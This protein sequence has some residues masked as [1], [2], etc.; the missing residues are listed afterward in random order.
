MVVE[1]TCGDNVLVDL[2]RMTVYNICVSNF[3]EGYLK[4][5]MR[6]TLNFNHLE[7]FFCLAKSLSF[8]K[9]A[10]QLGLAQPVV[11]R[12]IKALEDHFS[13]QLFIRGRKSVQITGRGE[14]L[15][16]EL[17]PLYSEMISRESI[18]REQQDQ[19]VGTLRIGCL[20]ELGERMIIAKIAAFRAKNPALKIDV[21]FLKSHEI[22]E[23]LKMGRLD[24]GITAQPEDSE[25]IRSYILF[26]EE[27]VLV[28]NPKCGRLSLT[29]PSELP[30]VAYRKDDPL[31][32][33][34]L[35]HASPRLQRQ[36]LNVAVSVNSQKSMVEFIK[37]QPLCA[38]L[39]RHT[40]EDELKSGKLVEVGKKKL[41][42]KIFLMHGE[43]DYL[44]RRTKD[45]VDFLR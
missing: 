10:E 32:F 23:S 18:F 4:S 22:V 40:V 29:K 11:S 36:S 7:C 27:S 13:T 8:S 9:T 14:E 26:V 6:N 20:R 38:V 12:Q 37:S 33:A 21:Q 41:K 25:S 39:P 1:S 31:M 44:E 42:T 28:A 45:F 34:F 5:I 30:L 16:Q 24:V 2:V 3:Y 19:L 43:S 17:H 35:Q 15:F